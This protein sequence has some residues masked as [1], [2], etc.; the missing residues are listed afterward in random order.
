[1]D[2]NNYHI[3]LADDHELILSSLKSLIN[4]EENLKVTGTFAT[5]RT[6]IEAI[7]NEIPDLC[8]IDLNMPGLTGLETAEILLKKHESLKIL[9]LTMHKEHSL[10]KKMMQIGIKGYV[11]KSCDRDEFIFAIQQVLKGKTYFSSIAIEKVIDAETHKNELNDHD[12]TKI[13]SLS[14][15]EMEII[16]YLCQ[17]FSNKQIGK[18]L[19]ISYKTIG[20]HRANIMQKMDV[21]NIVE[22]I[23]FSLKHHLTE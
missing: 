3:L 9:I 21:H 6:L 12:L 23:R 4:S 13:A 7:D 11:P 10:I 18:E 2:N 16:H 22:L 1:M 20:N 5:G 14:K 19:N 15:R 17:G 8:I